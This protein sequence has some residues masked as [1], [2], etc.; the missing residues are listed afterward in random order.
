MA[1]GNP[2]FL[3]QIRA[4][5]QMAQQNAPQP[6]NRPQPSLPFY[7]GIPN[8]P[9]SPRQ[10]PSRLGKNRAAKDPEKAF[11]AL[12]KLA[13]KMNPQQLQQLQQ[14]MG[15]IFGQ[16][17]KGPNAVN[18]AAEALG[19]MINEKTYR[20]PELGP[21][22]GKHATA[23]AIQ[24]LLS[25]MG[26]TGPGRPGGPGINP[27]G[28]PP[29]PVGINPPPGQP[30]IGFP[31]G[32]PGVMGQPS[33]NLGGIQGPMGMTAQQGSFQPMGMAQAQGGAQLPA[34][35]Q[36]VQQQQFAK[37]QQ[38]E[39][40][41]SGTVGA[42]SATQNPASVGAENPNIQNSSANKSPV[43]SSNTTPNYGT[44]N[45]FGAGGALGPGVSTGQL[46]S[47]ITG[48]DMLNTGPATAGQIFQA[49]YNPLINMAGQ[50]DIMGQLSTP[51]RSNVGGQYGTGGLANIAQQTAANQAAMQG[52]QGAQGLIA[53]NVQQQMGAQQLASQFDVTGRQQQIQHQNAMLQPAT[54]G[55]ASGFGQA[56]QGM[57]KMPQ[58]L[59]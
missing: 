12:S 56:I 29:P 54:A 43:I 6:G 4:M 2:Q 7:P 34:L 44:G 52:A 22:E 53:G 32:P 41:P 20:G 8:M 14:G 9:R 37:R 28:P 25:Q 18:K 17:F 51:G 55:V 33:L 49:Q 5:Q 59:G 1:R 16:N 15:N 21:G 46:Q 3:A 26:F 48:S 42:P 13:K 27:P 23:G 50:S 39:S 11:G 58:F 19:G 38:G 40:A 36:T 45:Q 30:P 35:G 31:P 10:S 57:N 24:N 47:A